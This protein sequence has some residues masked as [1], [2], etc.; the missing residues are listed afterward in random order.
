M[1]KSLRKGA[2]GGSPSGS[3]RTG[4]GRDGL[5]GGNSMIATGGLAAPPGN[6]S[7]TTAAAP[8]APATPVIY[9]K[10]EFDFSG[11]LTSDML[12]ARKVLSGDPLCPPPCKANV[13][14]G[15]LVRDVM[16]VR[17]VA[18]EGFSALPNVGAVDPVLG[19]LAVG[20]AGGRVK[21]YGKEGVERVLQ[22]PSRKDV[23]FLQFDV[24]E[25]RSAA[26]RQLGCMALDMQT[27]FRRLQ[28]RT[29]GTQCVQGRL[30]SV[31]A[32]DKLLVWNL[33]DGRFAGSATAAGLQLS[34]Q[35][36]YKTGL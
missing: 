18:I 2:D 7:P 20:C 1:F 16:P 29:G 6:A 26:A 22:L 3:L 5:A 28:F 17:Q 35:T 19:L 25:V 15:G 13:R 36:L 21:V 34:E 23:K 4:G 31:D 14:C 12:V 9:K 8:A 10:D 24:N 30:I 11:P 33:A 32:R 27:I